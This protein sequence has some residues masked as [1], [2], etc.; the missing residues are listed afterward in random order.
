MDRMTDGT[1]QQARSFQKL[2]FTHNLHNCRVRKEKIPMH[3]YQICVSCLNCSVS[4]VSP[5]TLSMVMFLCFT[6]RIVSAKRT[7]FSP[8]SAV[9]VLR[10]TLTDKI[11]GCLEK[12]VAPKCS[13]A[14]FS[15]LKSLPYGQ[16]PGISIRLFIDI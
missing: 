2:M 3:Y 1:S 8:F 16:E 7:L 9:P 10:L 5:S 15:A 13:R 14:I 4:L 12:L 6:T 11:P